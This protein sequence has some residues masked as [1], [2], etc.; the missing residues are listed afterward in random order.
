MS[1]FDNSDFVKI[2]GVIGPQQ[3]RTK[4][5]EWRAYNLF[6]KAK[7]IIESDLPGDFIEI[8]VWKGGMSALLGYMV[9]K[10]NNGRKVWS[11]DSFQGM[12]DSIPEIDGWDSTSPHVQ[13]RNFNFEDFEK[14]CFDMMG[15]KEDTINIRPGWVADTMPGAAN[16]VDKLGILRIDVDWYEPTKVVIETLYPKLISNGYLICDDYGYWKGARKAIDDYRKGNN[17]EDKIIQT[18]KNATLKKG[19]EHWWR[20]S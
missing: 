11:Y 3:N 9:E 12:S 10:E 6:H 16:E 17:I 14:T 18:L 7:T 19:T 1:L 8:G 2:W 20:K 4:C 15:L 13:L 5:P